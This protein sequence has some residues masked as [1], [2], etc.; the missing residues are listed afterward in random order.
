[1]DV[2]VARSDSCRERVP[3]VLRGRRRV[4]SFPKACAE[5][6]KRLDEHGYYRTH[7]FERKQGLADV[8]LLSYPPMLMERTALCGGS[9]LKCFVC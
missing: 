6:L 8:C 9:S 7:T 5:K 4:H 3:P 2:E 1:M